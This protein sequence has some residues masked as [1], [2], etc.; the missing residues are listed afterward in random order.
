VNELCGLQGIGKVVGSGK[1]TKLKGV[2]IDGQ[3]GKA[4]GFLNVLEPKAD[5]SSEKLEGS[6]VPFNTITGKESKD[7]VP[8][9]GCLGEE[10]VELIVSH[11][12]EGQQEIESIAINNKL[13]N[14]SGFC[15]Q[16]ARGEQKQ[17]EIALLLEELSTLL[18]EAQA[19]GV[20]LVGGKAEESHQE[21][22]EKK[23]GESACEGFVGFSLQGAEIPIL[24]G[25]SDNQDLSG[26][27]GSLKSTAVDVV[28]ANDAKKGLLI[29][30]DFLNSQNGNSK[31]IA[32]LN[33]KSGDGNSENVA[34]NSIKPESLLLTE[35][36]K[37]P[38]GGKE[39][40]NSSASLVNSERSNSA[41]EKVA[42]EI[43]E[44][45]SLKRKRGNPKEHFAMMETSGAPKVN[46]QAPFRVGQFDTQK[47]AMF[48]AESVD[49]A[50]RIWRD[51]RGQKMGIIQVEP[52]ELGKVRISVRSEQNIVHVH[53]TVDGAELGKLMQ[54]AADTLKDSFS[55]KGITMG[56]FSVDVG[57]DGREQSNQQ[58]GAESLSG[59][60]GYLGPE[61]FV[62][63]D[64][65]LL[66]RLD[67]YNGILY[68]IA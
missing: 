55:K 39:S 56:E 20:S 24:A 7:L 3:E 58:E 38:I 46:P 45:S 42:D 17:G 63:E 65:V 26:A 64:E 16:S 44:V 48:L 6:D 43:F 28:A 59:G 62:E 8:L 18:Q 23:K 27:R 11:K 40:L 52:P 50:V 54:Q 14:Y 49:R 25:E 9:L 57:G 13:N 31:N 60:K 36:N 5:A 10:I 12:I 53:V 61:D 47:A 2:G 15:E 19:E 33:N 22:E 37:A 51:S 66:G 21:K 30:K 32:V 68:W 4:S 34:E 1:D 41:L 67:L 35:E 29:T